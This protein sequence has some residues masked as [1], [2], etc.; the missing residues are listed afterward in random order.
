V[1][2]QQRIKKPLLETPQHM[3]EKTEHLLQEQNNKTHKII[4]KDADLEVTDNA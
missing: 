1:I 3:P 4:K 2:K